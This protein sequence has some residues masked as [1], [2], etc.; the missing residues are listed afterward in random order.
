[1]L[2]RVNTADSLPAA[3]LAP[4]PPARSAPTTALPAKPA[5][6]PRSPQR[7]RPA[8]QR[9]SYSQLADYEKC[10]YRFYLRRV[11][12]LPA[13]EAPPVLDQPEQQPALDAR[14]RGSIV[15]LVLEAL[16]FAAPDLPANE[17]I[18]AHAE[19]LGAELTAAE[20]DDIRALTDAFAGSPLCAR[21][22][23]ATSIRREAAFAFTLDPDGAGPL[24]NGFVDVIAREPDGTVLVVDYKSHRLDEHHTPQSL[25][26]RDYATQ[27]LVYALA[28]L[29][30]GA[31]R[32]E[33]V[34][35]LL[36]RPEEPVTAVYQQADAPELAAKLQQ[37]ATGIIEH[38]YPV[39]SRP[40]RDLCAE[41]PGRAALCSHPE[42]RTLSPLQPAPSPAAPARHS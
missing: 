31:P 18:A 35:L 17:D 25:V 1:V 27:Q 13:V 39:T 21:L 37:L 6:V 11:L 34:H 29:R 14:T 28:A 22:A 30:D 15:H 33:V 2:C 4:R 8:P 41:C 32:V 36:E 10:G 3:A 40:H 12:G 38:R 26:E 23:Q 42:S 7:P 5:A 19:R 9:L 24:V 20:L 16:D